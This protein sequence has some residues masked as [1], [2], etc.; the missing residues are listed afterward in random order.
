MSIS[1]LISWTGLASVE[2]HASFSLLGVYE[3]LME[4]VEGGWTRDMEGA[5]DE[6]AGVDT[7]TPRSVKLGQR[8][9]VKVGDLGGV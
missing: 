1:W 2:P 3:L 4:T 7:A 8:P 6:S 9:R 5:I